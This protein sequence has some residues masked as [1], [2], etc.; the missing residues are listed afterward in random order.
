[1]S[2]S[3]GP[4]M[5]ESS[6]TYGAN[7]YIYIYIYLNPQTSMEDEFRRLSK[8][9]KPETLNPRPPPPLQHVPVMFIEPSARLINGVFHGHTTSWI[10]MYLVTQRRRTAHESCALEHLSPP[11]PR[12]QSLRP[13]KSESVRYTCA[14]SYTLLRSHHIPFWAVL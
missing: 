6:Y 10:T 1:M 13:A 9:S 2:E 7:I 14:C 12:P 11:P 8:S 3:L 4:S 5:S